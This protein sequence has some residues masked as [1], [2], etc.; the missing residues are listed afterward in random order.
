M[1]TWFTAD[2]HIGHK[3]M[4]HHRAAAATICA[5]WESPEIDAFVID[6]HDRA[7]AANWDALVGPDDLVWVLGD[8]SAG[9]ARA[10]RGA[11]EWLAARPGRKRLI[12]G[13]HDGC[14]PLHRDSHKWQPEY[15]W[16][17]ETV[18][19]AGRIRAGGVSVLLSHFSYSSDH[20]AEARY[21]QWRLRD[22]GELLIHGHIHSPERRNGRELHVGV[23]AWELKPVAAQSIEQL[24]ADYQETSV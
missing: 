12:A 11:L 19:S 13:N 7:L 24:I 6:W 16:V 22:E 1:N 9:G 17:F 15:L 8:I 18:Q 20:T 5:P 2:L 4:A 3:L 21:N 10:Q 23:D 14:H